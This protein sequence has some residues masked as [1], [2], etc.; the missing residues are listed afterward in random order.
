MRTVRPARPGTESQLAE[1]TDGS[2]DH[3]T[4]PYG[5]RWSACRQR[6]SGDRTTVTATSATEETAAP[7]TTP[8]TTA[9]TEPKKHALLTPRCRVFILNPFSDGELVVET[10]G[11]WQTHNGEPP[12]CRF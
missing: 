3:A 6:C 4:L 2:D 9:E 7:E 11:T 8:E 10:T 12:R 1:R 5:H